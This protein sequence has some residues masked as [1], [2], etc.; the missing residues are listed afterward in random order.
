LYD[1]E[2]EKYKQYFEIA[3]AAKMFAL[4]VPEMIEG[5]IMRF[6]T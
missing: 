4:M 1:H 6:S 2:Y 5:G 3:G